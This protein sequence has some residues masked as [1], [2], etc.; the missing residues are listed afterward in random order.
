MQPRNKDVSMRIQRVFIV[1]GTGFLGYH[2]IQEFLGKG[3]HVTAVGL[4]PAPP[5]SLYPERVKMII[6]NIEHLRDD[7]LLDILH[8]HDAL[9]FA[10]G[11]DDRHTLPKPAYPLFQHANVETPRR[12]LILAVRAGVRRAVVLG[13]YF[14]HFNRAWPELKLAE[15]HPYIR[16]RVEQEQAVTSVPGMDTCVLELPYIFGQLPVQGWKPLWAPLIG[17][18]CKTPIVF[19]MNGG[20]ACVSAQTVGKAILSA[21]EQGQP[22]TCYQVCDE[23][24]TWTELLSRLGRADGRKIRVVSLPRWLIHIGLY[25]T[26]SLHAIQNK[27]AGLDLRRFAPLQTAKTFLDPEPARKALG[28]GPGDLDQA[29]R[30]TIAAYKGANERESA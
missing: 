6:Q 4:P 2:A 14:S 16:S 24:L 23:N 28:Y 19:Y 30:E 5:A 29:F 8:G 13:S 11:L 3:W 21:I 22:G 26:W 27:E 12:L 9:V 18:I 7:E 1:G 17:Y 10:A 15:H 25:A 20:S